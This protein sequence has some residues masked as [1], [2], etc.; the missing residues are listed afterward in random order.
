VVEA[1]IETTLR[2]IGGSADF[3][4]VTDDALY[5]DR[6]VHMGWHQAG[7]SSFSRLLRVTD[8]IESI[9]R[10][11]SQHLEEMLL[12]SARLRPVGWA[13][14]LAEFARRAEHSELRWWLYGSGALAVRGVHIVPGDLDLAVDDP[15]EAARV[16]DDL[17]VEPVTRHDAWIAEWTA[18]A[19]YGALIEFTSGPRSVPEADE[20]GPVAASHLEVVSW[21]GHSVAVPRLDLQLSVAERRGLR[22]RADL[23]RRAI[24]DDVG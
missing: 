5:Q 17:L 7:S 8:D 10:R 23:I 13:D 1:V 21:R 19:F 6:L 15:D 12:Q 2:I 22:D 16:L 20:Q 9:H 14:A 3:V 24:K 11:F 4:V 18:R